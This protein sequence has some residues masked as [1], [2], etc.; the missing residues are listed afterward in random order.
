ITASSTPSLHDALPIWMDHPVE[1]ADPTVG[2]GDHRVGQP[3]VEDVGEVA[4]PRE[5][6]V[7]AV[8]RDADRL[9]VPGCE[10]AV[11]APDLRQLGRRSEEHT[12]EL[13]SREN[14][15]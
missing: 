2:V 13:Q 9:R 15:V 10:L 8:D 14:L 1:L 4:L 5:V 3:R 6:R 12:S 11:A 7:D